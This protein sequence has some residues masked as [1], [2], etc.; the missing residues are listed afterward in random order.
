M[1]ESLGETLLWTASY[2]G[3]SNDAFSGFMLRKTVVGPGLDEP[4]ARLIQWI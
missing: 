2:P 4:L 1:H 3:G